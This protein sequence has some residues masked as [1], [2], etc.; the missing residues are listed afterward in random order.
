MDEKLQFVARRL[1]GLDMVGER[2]FEPPTPWS[3]TRCS[4]R[5]S[6]SPTSRFYYSLLAFLRRAFCMLLRFHIMHRPL[7]HGRPGKRLPRVRLPRGF[8]A[9]SPRAP[10][11][12]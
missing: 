3:R 8:S 6:H 7:F 4:T 9:L 2:G 1:A 5:L 11:S 12:K 10:R